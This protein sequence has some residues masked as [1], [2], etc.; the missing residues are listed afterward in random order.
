MLSHPW[1]RTSDL[2]GAKPQM[3]ADR[4]KMDTDKGT[5]G[6][7]GVTSYK[8]TARKEAGAGEAGNRKP[9]GVG[10]RVFGVS[11]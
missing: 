4:G 11:R 5:K 6:S 8:S 10:R 1:P 2:E 7:K 9:C 3:D